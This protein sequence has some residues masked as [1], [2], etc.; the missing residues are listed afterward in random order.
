MR[1]RQAN[2]RAFRR[3]PGN[4]GLN[5]GQFVLYRMRYVL[6]GDLTDARSEFGG[7]ADQLNHLAAVLGLS[8]TDHAGISDACVLRIRRPIQKM[9]KTGRQARTTSNS[10]ETRIKIFA[11]TPYATSKRERTK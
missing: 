6:A 1:K 2:Q 3:H 4:Q 10:L 11:R 5:I 8:I 9:A 7:I